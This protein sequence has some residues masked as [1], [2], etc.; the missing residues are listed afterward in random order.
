MLQQ[1]S[2]RVLCVAD[3]RG[4]MANL[5]I[6]ENIAADITKETS[7]RSTSS[8]QTLGQITLSTLA[9]LVSMTIVR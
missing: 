4:K 6:Y 2:V 7:N 8:P 1:G 9:T 5:G 3:V